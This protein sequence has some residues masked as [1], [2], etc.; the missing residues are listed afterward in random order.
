MPSQMLSPEDL[1][2]AA[3]AFDA[4]LSSL[5]K[6]A[7]NISPHTARRLVARYVMHRALNGQRDPARLRVEAL[8]SVALA[9]RRHAR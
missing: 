3:D 8:A 5:P 9:A 2:A 6:H 7:S 4:A 1:K